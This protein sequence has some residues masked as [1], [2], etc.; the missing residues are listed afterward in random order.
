MGKVKADY[1]LLEVHEGIVGQHLGAR[2]LAK[3]VL[4]VGYY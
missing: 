4:W 3:N 2:E 1:T